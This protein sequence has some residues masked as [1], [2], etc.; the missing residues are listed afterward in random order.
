M[1]V[2][3]LSESLKQIQ[4][5]LDEV[6]VIVKELQGHK[7][8]RAA[9]KKAA[10]AKPS[11]LTE[12][13]ITKYKE[14]FNV[15]YDRWLGGDEVNVQAELENMDADELRT[16]E[17]REGVYAGF[18]TFLRKLAGASAVALAGLA[19]DYAGFQGGKTPSPVA[20]G[21]I[22]WLT[23]AVPAAFIVLG[24]LLARRYPIS[25]ERHAEVRRALDRRGGGV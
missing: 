24:V 3:E 11:P 21:T 18:F 16:D 20:L 23:G 7:K 22:R 6:L 13:E 25:R 1:N 9:A 10:K 5:Q 17:R 14:Q 12:E 2:E 4:K 15:L 8:Q 19:L